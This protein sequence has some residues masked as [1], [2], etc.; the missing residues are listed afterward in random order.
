MNELTKSLQA[1]KTQLLDS[2]SEVDRAL[3]IEVDV[4]EISNKARVVTEFNKRFNEAQKV[5]S[6][7]IRERQTV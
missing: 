3:E 4:T 1:L 5:F 2:L 6:N 7:G